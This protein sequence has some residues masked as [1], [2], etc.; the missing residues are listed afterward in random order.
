MRSR[1]NIGDG[2]M[3]KKI[4]QYVFVADAFGEIPVWSLQH[5]K[6][7]AKE[8]Y[9]LTAVPNLKNIKGAKQRDLFRKLND[10][11]GYADIYVTGEITYKYDQERE[12]N[13]ITD[14]KIEEI[15]MF[16]DL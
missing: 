11:F 1:Y 16:P 13:I 6:K 12:A 7:E 3:K 4:K 15:L 2:V 10:Y 9:L 8:A 5:P 14:I